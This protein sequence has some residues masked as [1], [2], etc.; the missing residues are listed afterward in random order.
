VAPIAG[1]INA[2]E[3]LDAA[4]TNA[5]RRQRMNER[6]DLENQMSRTSNFVR[7]GSNT[8]DK[9]AEAVPNILGDMAAAAPSGA[10]AVGVSGVK[11]VWNA[12]SGAL[13]KETRAEIVG[14]LTNMNPSQSIAF[15]ERLKSLQAKGELTTKAIRATAVAAVTSTNE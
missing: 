14:H 6:L 7:G 9:L 8:P 13:G 10:Q 1:S 4:A 5:N 12:M 15:L 11:G 3:Q 2:R